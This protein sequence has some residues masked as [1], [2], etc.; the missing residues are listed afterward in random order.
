MQLRSEIQIQTAIKAMT[1]VVLPAL[2]PHDKI[3]AEQGQLVVGMLA[4]LGQQLPL[5]YRFDRDELTRLHA[6]AA[7]LH[8]RASWPAS[9][10]EAF[11]E[12]DSAAAGA[13]DVL[14]RARAEPHELEESI[15]RLRHAMTSVVRTV[16]S[17]DDADARSAVR[18]SVMAMSEQQLLRD[19][20]WLLMQNWEPNPQ[21]VPPIEELLSVSEP[22]GEGA[23]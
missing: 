5:Q 3:A 11:A 19:R 21:A 12:M 15:K 16:F 2:D 8:P 17:A 23:T 10:R 9:A 18:D 20:S 22:R 13:E 6:F 7:A 1:E 4:L 14:D